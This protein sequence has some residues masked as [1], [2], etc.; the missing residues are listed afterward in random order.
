M[1]FDVA[2]QQGRVREKERRDHVWRVVKA[3]AGSLV[4]GSAGLVFAFAMGLQDARWADAWTRV[5]D[6]S[7]PFSAQQVEVGGVSRG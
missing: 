6:A 7:S 4:A 2:L 3:V 1:R 5:G